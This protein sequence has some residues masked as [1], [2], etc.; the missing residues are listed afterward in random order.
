M[1]DNT[2][3]WLDAI[4]PHELRCP[5]VVNVPVVDAPHPAGVDYVFFIPPVAHSHHVLVP[6]RNG[7]R[8][9]T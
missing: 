5:N 8:G 2:L 7:I 4:E 3:R 9:R 1:V 6:Q